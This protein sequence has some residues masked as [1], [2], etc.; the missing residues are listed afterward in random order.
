MQI[1]EITGSHNVLH[2]FSFQTNRFHKMHPQSE[3]SAPFVYLSEY[4]PKSLP[5]ADWKA[6]FVRI[7][8]QY[9][10]KKVFFLMLLM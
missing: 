2:F 9:N 10:S 3:Q 4:Q 5:A 6:K 7:E 1:Y 8:L